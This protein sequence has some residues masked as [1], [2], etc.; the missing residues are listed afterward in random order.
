M[1]FDEIEYVHF[2]YILIIIIL[3]IISNIYLIKERLI[4]TSNAV[5]FSPVNL[6]VKRNKDI[7]IMSH[8]AMYIF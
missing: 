2:L 4:L 8:G 3:I 1:P 7:L 6:S 5:I